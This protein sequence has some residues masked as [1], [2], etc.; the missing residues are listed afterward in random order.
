MKGLLFQ[1]L[2][3]IS[4]RKVRTT[5]SPHGPY[6]LAT[7]ATMGMTKGGNMATLSKPK[8]FPEFGLFSATREH[9]VGIASNRRSARYGEFVSKPCTHRPSHSENFHALKQKKFA[10]NTQPKNKRPHFP[11]FYLCRC[12]VLF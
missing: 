3:R 8:K 6:G 2:P 12:W 1:R 10:T 4:W 9:E 7:R 5:S 11:S